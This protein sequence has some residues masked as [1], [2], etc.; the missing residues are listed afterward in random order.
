MSVKKTTPGTPR[1]VGCF[2]WNGMILSSFYIIRPLSTKLDAEV[3]T[4]WFSMQFCNKFCAKIYTHCWNTDKSHRGWGTFQVHPVL[5][6]ADGRLFRTVMCHVQ[7]I[8][9]STK[10][11]AGFVRVNVLRVSVRLCTSGNPIRYIQVVRLRLTDSVHLRSKVINWTIAVWCGIR[12][13]WTFRI[14]TGLSLNAPLSV[15]RAWSPR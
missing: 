10:K 12:F 4:L 13:D 7:R 1:N 9:V 11:M 15:D 5:C 3:Y 2:G 14:S 8:V 6:T